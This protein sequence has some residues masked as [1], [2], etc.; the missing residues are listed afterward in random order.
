MSHE[1]FKVDNSSPV[2]KVSFDVVNERGDAVSLSDLPPG[3]RKI[4]FN[5]DE[6]IT[7][8]EKA[9]D[10]KVENIE[11]KEIVVEKVNEPAIEKSNTKEQISL[12]KQI[13]NLNAIEELRKQ[14]GLDTLRT[15]ETEKLAHE[16]VKIQEKL[17]GMKQQTAEIVNIQTNLENNNVDNISNDLVME[18]NETQPPK[19]EIKELPEEW[20]GF[21][22]EWFN[23]NVP[24]EYENVDMAKQIMRFSEDLASKDPVFRKKLSEE[25]FEYEKNSDLSSFSGVNEEGKLISKNGNVTNYAY[26]L[27]GFSLKRAEYER[28]LVEAYAKEKGIL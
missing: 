7:A 13:D 24:S 10:Y 21:K 16:K 4:V 15:D 18:P 28:K 22:K 17:T 25:I 8:K 26:N 6:L 23:G 12:T 20:K 9:I 11:A 5:K 19:L 1:G 14:Q 2:K 3:A 27:A